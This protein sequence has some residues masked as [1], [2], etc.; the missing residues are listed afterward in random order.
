MF[1][2]FKG[3]FENTL[4]TYPS[5]AYFNFHNLVKQIY[6]FIYVHLSIFIKTRMKIS[7]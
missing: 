7:L 3:H 5:H 2:K 1:L 4:Q 6:L